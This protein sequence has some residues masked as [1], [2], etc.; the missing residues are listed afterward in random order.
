MG[1][2]PRVGSAY[3]TIEMDLEERLRGLLARR[4]GVGP[5]EL[6][7]LLIEAGFTWRQGKGDHRVYRHPRRFRKLAIDPRKPLKPVYVELA[8]KAIREVLD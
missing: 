3:G 7:A 4:N 2:T 6:H 8:V 1:S 5:E